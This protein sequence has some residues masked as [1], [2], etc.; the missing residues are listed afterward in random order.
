MTADQ[1]WMRVGTNLPDHPRLMSFARRLGVDKRVAIGSLILLWSWSQ[2]YAPD[3]NLSAYD[4]ETLADV[5]AYAGD[6][7]LLWTALVTTGWVD[8][9]GQLHKWSDWG[10]RIFAERNATSAKVARHR[11]RTAA[12]TSSGVV[13]VEQPV[14]NRYT[15]VT[16]PLPSN[17]ERD[18]EEDSL[19]LSRAERVLHRIRDRHPDRVPL[20]TR[21]ER[22]KLAG[23]AD[24]DLDA[25]A[26]MWSEILDGS[27]GDDYQH[28][29]LSLNVV[30]AGLRA[31]QQVGTPRPARTV[32]PAGP[33]AH[34]LTDEQRRNLKALALEGHSV[35]AQVV[36]NLSAVG[37][38]P[39]ELYAVA[40][41]VLGVAE[42]PRA[43]VIDGHSRIVSL[44]SRRLAQ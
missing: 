9:D 43:V 5:C 19:S 15:P 40:V 25:V 21:T 24:A 27:Y 7:E 13:T 39:E 29:N 1:R 35:A 28:A 6:S 34:R 23:L 22:E 32:K 16:S 33:V 37:A 38:L 18:R 31:Y 4:H 12:E 10:G 30:L 42:P 41:Q 44:D 17:R 14:R 36:A 11:E 2:E 3:G 20:P 8:A 26:D